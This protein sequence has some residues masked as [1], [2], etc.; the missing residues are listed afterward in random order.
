MTLQLTRTEENAAEIDALTQAL[1]SYGGGRVGLAPLLADLPQ[2]MHRSFAPG[3]AVSRALAWEPA[4][5]LDPL[6]WPQ[7][8]TNSYRTQVTRE[9]LMVSWYSKAGEGA[10]ISVIDLATQRYR[11]V[12]L[13]TPTASGGVKPVRAHAGG[14]VWQG[15]FLHVAATARGVLTF[16]LDDLMLDPSEKHGYR[17]L[18]PVRY[19][20]RADALEGVEG[21]RYSFL[22]VDRSEREPALVVGEYGSTK[23]TQRLAHFGLD[24]VSGV[25]AAGPDG[26]TRPLRIDE[27]GQAQMQGASVVEGRYFVTVSHGPWGLGSVLS[28]LPGSFRRHR[29]ATPMGPEDLCY[30]PP[31]GSLWSVSEHP[32][33]RWVFAMERSYFSV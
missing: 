14:I 15:P 12:L 33:R 23:Q 2:R 28:G 4:D 24:S 21:L 17:Y 16:R 32:G 7:G 13:V 26:V 22:S 6:W 30:H 18:L 5:D 3:R 19:S 29:W 11:H 9:M 31:S 8:V 27:S 1:A 25:L 10:R 20:Y